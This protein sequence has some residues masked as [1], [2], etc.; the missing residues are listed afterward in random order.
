MGSGMAAA[1]SRTDLFTLQRIELHML[2]NV[3][4][5]IRDFVDTLSTKTRIWALVSIVVYIMLLGGL[6]NLAPILFWPK[7]GAFVIAVVVTIC[8]LYACIS[9]RQDNDDLY[10]EDEQPTY[11]TQAV[12]PPKP[13][14]PPRVM[15]KNPSSDEPP[16][17]NV[18]IEISAEPPPRRFLS[19]PKEFREL[20]KEGDVNVLVIHSYS[21]VNQGRFK[22]KLWRHETRK[23]ELD[24]NPDV[25]I[26]LATKIPISPTDRETKIYCLDRLHWWSHGPE[27]LGILLGTVGLATLILLLSSSSDNWAVKLTIVLVVLIT[28]G[29]WYYIVWIKWAYRFLIFTNSK[30]RFPYRP[31][32]KLP[33]SDPSTDLNKL[34]GGMIKDSSFWANI[35]GYG[36]IRTET[37]ATVVDKWLLEDVRFVRNYERKAQR[38]DQLREDAEQN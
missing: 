22:K 27:Q 24:D 3:L 29:I 15:L 9:L 18:S 38:L 2:R 11:S 23:L 7:F 19:R 5:P 36:V 1:Y 28:G 13:A 14:A 33:R 4:Q 35:F 31:P 20:I 16:P 37:V 10:S 32:F 6:I 30:I 21:Q 17:A 34:T 26:R 12:I 25:N 8:F